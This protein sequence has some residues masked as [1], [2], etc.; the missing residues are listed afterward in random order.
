MTQ[1]T[2]PND[3]NQSLRQDVRLL[4][5]ILGETIKSQEGERTYQVIEQVRALTKQGRKDELDATEVIQSMKEI[6]GNME[7]EEAVPVARSFSLFLTLANIAEQHHRIRRRR[8]Y[9]LDEDKPPQRGSIKEAVSRLRKEGKTD[10]EIFE[11][12][13]KVNVELVL[14]A[15]PTEVKRRT[16]VQ[17][18]NE[19]GEILQHRD[20]PLLTENERLETEEQLK[21]ILHEIWC[22]NEIK[23]RRPTPMEEARGGLVVIEQNLWEV[24]P[25]FLRE[26]SSDVEEI[27]GREL[28]IDFCPVRFGSWMGGDR[29]G[30]PNVTAEVTR[31]VIANARWLAAELYYREIDLLRAELSMADCSSELR[32]IVGDAPEPYRA[33]LAGVRA[34]MG[35][36]REYFAKKLEGGELPESEIYES[37]HELRN[38]LMICFRSLHEKNSGPIANGRLMDILRRLSCFGVSLVKLDF[39][40]ESE[41]HTNA[42]SAITQALGLGVYAEW[43]EEQ[44]VEFKVLIKKAEERATLLFKGEA[45]IVCDIN[46]HICEQKKAIL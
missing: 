43:S 24:L 9:L 38:D 10:T 31:R 4:G 32:E 28:P 1:Q 8:E 22:T 23:R 21:R 14:T 16:V 3:P 46:D 11:T 13:S 2:K 17:K 30:N 34:K 5:R 26:T 41:A 45:E 42:L 33:F 7:I 44:R 29:D 39:R 19:I 25:K 6:L 15:H 37:E 20:S 12:L 27:L 35:S 18:L 36:T 40:Q